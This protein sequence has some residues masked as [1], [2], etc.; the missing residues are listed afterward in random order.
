M[1]DLKIDTKKLSISD[2]DMLYNIIILK[3]KS[4]INNYD[5]AVI[6]INK[7]FNTNITSRDLQVALDVTM[8][9]EEEDLQLIYNNVR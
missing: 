1:K 9:I 2:I 8:S 7:E 6:E 3:D 4:L 5:L